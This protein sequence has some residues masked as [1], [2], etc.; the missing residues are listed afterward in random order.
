[1]KTSLRKDHWTRTGQTPALSLNF[2]NGVNDARIAYSG[3]ANGTRVNSAGT[4]VAATTPRFD[5]DPVTL[6]AR[7]L[8]VEEARTNLLTRSSALD[9]A[10]WTKVTG[11]ATVTADATTSPDGTANADAVNSLSAASDNGVLNA[12]VVANDSAAYSASLYVKKNTSS[13]V[14]VDLRLTG[15]TGLTY[16]YILNLDTGVITTAG[17]S[18]ATAFSATAVGG[19]WYHVVITGPNNNTGNVSAA[20]WIYGCVD[21]AGAT[22]VGSTYAWGA[23]LEAGAFPTSYI[24]TVAATVTR[25]ADSAV[26]TGANFS[27]WFN[28]AQSTFVAG[29]NI[30]Y[31]VPSTT[32]PRVLCT[33][34]ATGESNNGQLLFSP[35]VTGKIGA[36]NSFSGAA[37]AGR[38]D[39]LAANTPNTLIKIA[40]AFA[41]NDRAISVN[42]AAAVTSAAGALPVSLDRLYIGNG[43]TGV[44]ALNGWIQYIQYFP[45]RLPDAR[46]QNLSR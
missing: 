42:G 44:T 17:G 9:N 21:G 34:D 6:A 46:L 40:G 45:T 1:M 24:P 8:L 22:A 33:S 16:A 38:V 14:R 43:A 12:V 41:L 19:G 20:L 5:Y 3:G 30:P 25:T 27:P 2:L 28:S 26:M 11:N 15:G 37:N 35:G 36:I 18:A 23:Q 4:I 13:R 29:F 7:G 10:A 32:G 31:A 39:A